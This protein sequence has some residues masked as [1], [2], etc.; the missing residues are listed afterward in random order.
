M[1]F[2]PRFNETGFRVTSEAEGHWQAQ[3]LTR[4]QEIWHDGTHLVI[5]GVVQDVPAFN[6]IAAGAGRWVGWSETAGGIVKSWGGEVL[7]GAGA[8]AM[9]FDGKFAYVDDRGAMHKSLFVQT[10]PDQTPI[11]V[12]MGSITEVR[13]S[14]NCVCWMDNGQ[15]YGHWF[16][17]GPAALGIVPG[18]GRPIPIETPDGVYVLT[19]TQT[20]ILLRKFRETMGWRFDNGGQ[21]FYP[22]AVYRADM[23]AIAVA[24][25]NDKGVQDQLY[26]PLNAP[27]IDLTQPPEPEPPALVKPEI[28]VDTWS[29]DW[30]KPGTKARWHDRM[31]P[32]LGLVGECWI[33]DHG[34]FHMALEHV[35]GRGETG[36]VRTVKSCNEPKPPDPQP[37]VT[38]LSVSFGPNG[39]SVDFQ[40]LFTAPEQW[41]FSRERCGGLRFWGAHLLDFDH[42]LVTPNTYAAFVA[43]GAFQKLA[44][45]KLPMEIGV[46]FKAEDV[47]LA[48]ER[49]K[50]AGGSV[51]RI[52]YDHA[53]IEIPVQQFADW[54]HQ[55]VTYQPS[56]QVGVYAPFP[57]QSVAQ[58]LDRVQQFMTLGAKPAFLR[59]DVDPNQR[60]ALT[61]AVFDQFRKACDQANIQLQVVINA[62]DKSLDAAYISEASGWAKTVLT[63]GQW[64]GLMVESWGGPDK[65]PRVQPHNL[66]ESDASS[67]TSLLR[68]VL[69]HWTEPLPKPPDPQPPEK[70]ALQTIWG[71][72]VGVGADG[73]LTPIMTPTARCEL[74]PLG[75]GK[76]AWTVNGKYVAAEP[77]QLLKADRT[78]A[79][80]WERFTLRQPTT[81]VVQ[82][83]AWTGLWVSAWD[84]GQILAKGPSNGTW[85]TFTKVPYQATTPITSTLTTDHQIFRT[86]GQPWRWKGVSAFQLLDRYAKGENIGS[87]LSA[88]KGFNLL[89]VWPYVT[90]PGTG[91]EPAPHDAT[92]SFLRTCADAGFYVE[93]TLLTDDDPK[94]IEPAK[95]MVSWLAARSPANLVLE[96]GNEPTTNKHIDTTALKST[97]EQSGFLF[98]SGD[99]ED[100]HRFFGTFLT[101]HTPRDSE[102]PRKAHDLLEYYTGGG[103][104]APTDPAHKVP[105]VAD[106]PI[107]PD[108]ATGDREGDFR[109]YFGTC[110]IL[111]AGGTYHYEGGKFGRVP[112]EDEAKYAA[113]SLDAL[114]AFPADE[115][116]KGYRRIDEG[117]HSLRTYVVG[118]SMVRIRP[119]TPMSPEPGWTALD[120]RGI[121]WRRG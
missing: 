92:L 58:I 93:L 79:G 53:F 107:R 3:W 116:L 117:S 54:Y 30:T 96:I 83:Q 76:T 66:P 43:C 69:E 91:W 47:I 33:D 63:L 2:F 73:F 102:W 85:E 9:S 1:G 6:E 34:S 118:D 59:L 13:I 36:A 86:N 114:N 37:P 7:T 28:T 35:G 11:W 10:A 84:T 17:V 29:A 5:A 8:P 111:G 78:T 74:V 119:T 19:Q 39:G 110:S 98:S 71:T 95:Q 23:N 14:A 67:H 4:D 104:S 31:N 18:E 52:A 99:Y 41:T 50:A 75:N 26:F 61:R 12:A 120:S 48:I 70:Y 38:R 55:L 20:G 97:C 113:V 64:D 25:S 112:N 49:V 88:F 21:T 94:R 80:D 32:D 56:L 22:D 90:W 68:E 82:M 15:P 46:D 65:A 24:Y 115:P 101:A 51:D 62:R 103:P 89:R 40:A 57:L 105:C 109:A 60:G 72:Y 42:T 100:S 87:F 77:G 108:Q 45:W 27:K 16:G 106:E 121:L 81:T 44:Q